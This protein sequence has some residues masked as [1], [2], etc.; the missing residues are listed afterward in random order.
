MTTQT[1]APA[2]E[3]GDAPFLHRADDWLGRIENGFTLIAALCI[4]ALMLL[5]IAQVLGRQL[6]DR[7]VVGYIDF[8][9]LS[10]ATFAFMG[11]AYCQRVGGHVRMDLFVN[12]AKGRLHWAMELFSTLLPLFL[13]GVLIY[14]SWEH[15]LR[16]YDSGDST[17][18]IQL[19]VW[20]S[21]LLVPVSF[22]LLFLRLLVQL[23]GFVRLLR[24]PDAE[25]LAVPRMLTP[26]EL[27]AHQI[28]E[29]KPG[30]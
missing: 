6:F 5:G 14:Y 11:V 28:E 22:S 21:K 12:M 15:F 2:H 9:E 8:V 29:S 13:I 4:F 3:G 25:P 18:D 7:P 20:P 1:S 19:P 26:E 27:A 30:H 17:I 24:R 10:M 16:A 23:F